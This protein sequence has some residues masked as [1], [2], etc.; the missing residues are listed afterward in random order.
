MPLWPG[1]RRHGRRGDGYRYGAWHGGP[2]PLAAPFDVGSAVDELGQ[3][4]LEG[5]SVRDALRD[6]LRRGMEGGRGLSDL[7]RDVNRRRRQLQRRGDLTGT[8]SRARQMLDQATA[9]EREGLAAEDSDDARLAEM[10]LDGL[11]GRHRRSGS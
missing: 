6:L 7:R 10:T 2:D 8:L 9:A 11:A 1:R 5:R 3:E 4:M